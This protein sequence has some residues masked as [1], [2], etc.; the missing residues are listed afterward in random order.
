[1]FCFINGSY[2]QKLTSGTVCVSTVC[3]SYLKVDAGR[4]CEILYPAEHRGRFSVQ[5][6]VPRKPFGLTQIHVSLLAGMLILCTNTEH[7]LQSNIKFLAYHLQ[8]EVQ[9]DCI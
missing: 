2:V 8:S 5:M 4:S 1:M 6:Q 7:K 3:Y 9:E